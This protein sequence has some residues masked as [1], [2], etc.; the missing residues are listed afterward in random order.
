MLIQLSFSWIDKLEKR[1][2]D[3]NL[4][5]L[6]S[7]ILPCLSM[8]STRELIYL[9][10]LNKRQRKCHRAFS[11]PSVSEYFPM[12]HALWTPTHLVGESDIC[13]SRGLTEKTHILLSMQPRRDGSQ[14]L[15]TH[16]SSSVSTE[17]TCQSAVIWSVF[18]LFNASFH[19]TVSASFISTLASVVI[20][21]FSF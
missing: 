10:L 4:D 13:I 21:S 5:C 8:E 6:F 15:M 18:I 19:A 2:T 16:I 9:P 14:C 1:M 17:K 20:S 3:R 7:Q 12:R 11:R